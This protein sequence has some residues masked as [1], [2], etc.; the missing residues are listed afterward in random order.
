MNV[1]ETG[2][3]IEHAREVTLSGLEHT[4]AA[5]KSTGSTAKALSYLLHE[6]LG[7][8]EKSPWR[9]SL[10]V[11]SSQ[12]KIVKN[13]ISLAESGCSE[14]MR[15]FAYIAGDSKNDDVHTVLLF[16][17]MASRQLSG[18]TSVG[19]INIPATLGSIEDDMRF[20]AD[21]VESARVLGNEV[22]QELGLIDRALGSLEEAQGHAAEG[23]KDTIRRL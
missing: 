14:A 2:Q 1:E 16:G 12:F 7:V 11:A 18:Q 21:R 22:L 23:M 13:S 10:E 19:D 8:A 3:R 20:I 17:G 9:T 4:K 6:L 15:T 5:K